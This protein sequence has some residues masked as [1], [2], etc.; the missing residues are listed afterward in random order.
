LLWLTGVFVASTPG[1]GWG[2]V[3][4]PGAPLGRMQ[5]ERDFSMCRE[6]QK[7]GD[8]GACWKVWLKKHRAIGT[9]AEVAYAEEH[10][11]GTPEGQ[12][13]GSATPKPSRK[14]SRG[15]SGS[16]LGSGASTE[17]AAGESED[18]GDG[19][20]N[21][22]EEATGSSSKKKS[23]GKPRSK[24]QTIAERG[25]VLDLCGLAPEPNATRFVKQ[26]VVV[27]APSQAGRVES[28]SSIRSVHGGDHVRAVFASRFP[29]GRFH[30]VV[31]TIAAKPGWEVAA[32]L[33]L[34]TLRNHV[35]DA[36]IQPSA[37]E[38]ESEDA[39]ANAEREREFVRYSLGCTDYVVVPALTNHSAEWV[40][41]EIKTKKGTKKVKALDLKI[42][43]SMGI[44]RRDGARFVL[45]Q[46][47]TA[48]VPTLID[49][50]T[51]MAAGAIPDVDPRGALDPTKVVGAATQVVEL[52]GFI[53]AIPNAA[54]ELK[55]GVPDGVPGLGKCK[56]KPVVRPLLAA[57]SIDE[58]ASETCRKAYADG[59]DPSEATALAAT[60]ETR[61]RAFQLTR[62][63]QV[64]ARGVE[65]WKLFA[66][67]E[68]GTR[69]DPEALGFSLGQNEGVKTGWGFY[70]VDGQKNR[71]AYF[72][73]GSVG[74]GGDAGKN[75]LT[76][77]VPRTG[78]APLESR[79]EEYPQLGLKL[80]PWGGFSAL[81]W[82]YDAS[83]VGNSVWRLPSLVGGGGADVGF[84]LSSLTGMQELTVRVG[85]SYLAG[86][87]GENV[88]L[89]LVPIDVT[90]EKGWAAGRLTF[91]LGLGQ[92]TTLAT[93][94][95][96][97]TAQGG[98]D[99]TLT[100]TV[101]GANA[102]VGFDLMLTP[103]VSL[104]LDGTT[105]IHFNAASYTDADDDRREVLNGFD[106]REDHFAT[107]GPAFTLGITL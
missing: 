42:D 85:G 1:V 103:D 46:T 69:E 98:Q 54:C 88:G 47:V 17:T 51:D 60:C 25:E 23:G 89:S 50:A 107:V 14:K 57:S 38:H 34:D 40:E 105:R 15:T 64:Q 19:D 13:D 77:L 7:E 66:P 29:L 3:A 59:T 45:V 93:V 96:L 72:K 24:K 2:Q 12:D 79:V 62:A 58:R 41:R 61:V 9:E 53:S 63:L 6:L 27:F 86:L 5:A 37:L 16:S 10:V 102:H 65:G 78:E 84:D 26:R 30:N 21:E 22:D 101:V 76:E 92:S 4:K 32:D 18:E 39:E 70:A 68:K 52:P 81:T 11:A 31:T 56:E 33:S 75:D 73:V 82:N 95:V 35:E 104:R 90:L 87:D 97:K 20:E 100:A 106:R 48:S 99:Q 8:A 74:P 94:D 44:F 43:G 80:L 83:V 28:E 36:K 67:L 55:R 49:R 71:L 91:F